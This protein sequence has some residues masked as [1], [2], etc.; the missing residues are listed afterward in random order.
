MSVITMVSVKVKVS[1]NKDGVD[2]Y[3]RQKNRNGSC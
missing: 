3:H 2:P 1:Y